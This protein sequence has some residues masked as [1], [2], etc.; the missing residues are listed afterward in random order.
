MRVGRHERIAPI[1][2]LAGKPPRPGTILDLLVSRLAGEGLQITTQLPHV[3][4]FCAEEW[5]YGALI[6]HR[7]MSRPILQALTDIEPKGRAFCNRAAAS[8]AAQDR[9]AL[10]RRLQ[11]AGLPV[12]AFE[13]HDDCSA[14]LAA[15]TGRDVVV[16]AADGVIGRGSRV[17]FSHQAPLPPEPPFAGPYLIEDRVARDGA[18]RK[19]YVAGPRCFGLL[20][21]WPRTPDGAGVPF[22]PSEELRRLAFAAGRAAGLEIYGVDFVIGPGGPVIVDVNVFPGFRGVDGGAD[23]VIDHIRCRAS[24]FLRDR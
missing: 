18:D 19:L 2:C 22:D 9:P 11:S 17:L 24:E 12:P 21:T 4:G 13:R 23:A 6:V 20:K 16:K 5:P 14:A 1:I 7:G 3:A 15:A 10:L 8:L